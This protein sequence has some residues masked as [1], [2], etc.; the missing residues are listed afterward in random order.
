[1]SFAAAMPQD[2]RLVAG[3]WW[4]ADYDG[5]PLV[6]LHESLRQGLG[7]ALGDTLTFEIFGERITAEV[8]NFRSYAW[9]GGIDV[10][11]TFSPGVLDPFPTTLFVAVTARPG[12]ETALE[13]QL[14]EALPDIGFIA[15]G[16]TL[17]KITT[18]LS[19]LSLA[20]FLVGGLAV[21]NGLLVLAGSLA[22]GRDQRRADALITRVLGERRGPILAAA[23]LYHGLLAA[24]SVV[25]AVAVGI[26]FAAL[27]TRLLLEVQFALEAP[28]LLGVGLAT[29]VIVAVLGSLS[30]RKAI[31]PRPALY[32]RELGAE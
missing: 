10:L 18:A 26:G 22:M 7:V 28:A 14:A 4:G 31:A 8:A 15:I 25:V 32:L 3:T 21:A 19:Q 27:L 24:L 1:M 11:A 12:T 29:V 17:T 6:S 5:A 20:A 30:L 13:Q 9:Q 23:F 16:E 2:S